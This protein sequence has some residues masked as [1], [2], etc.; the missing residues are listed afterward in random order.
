MLAEILPNVLPLVLV[1]ATVR[2]AYAIFFVASLS[3]LGFGIQPPSPDWGIAIAENYGLIG[4]YWWTVIFDAAAVTSL[5]LG[6]NLLAD[7]LRGVFAR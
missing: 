6:L 3:F 4:C 2:F 5:V 1:E 7:G